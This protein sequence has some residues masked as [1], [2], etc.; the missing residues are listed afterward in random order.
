MVVFLR[1]NILLHFFR[2]S[3]NSFF[4]D[5]RIF[6]QVLRWKIQ[7]FFYILYRIRFDWMS[8]SEIISVEIRR[9]VG[10]ILQITLDVIL[11]KSFKSSKQLKN[12]N[13]H[14][15]SIGSQVLYE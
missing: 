6:R 9:M 10:N 8:E 2:I 4:P 15:R 14:S 12:W 7:G 11:I 3:P 5:I 1:S 13:V